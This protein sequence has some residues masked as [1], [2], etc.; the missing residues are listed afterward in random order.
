[1]KQHCMVVA[2]D[3][4]RNIISYFLAASRILRNV[5]FLSNGR[6]LSVWNSGTARH[7]RSRVATTGM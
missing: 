7:H 5:A 3:T 6:G 1:M 4:V 2:V